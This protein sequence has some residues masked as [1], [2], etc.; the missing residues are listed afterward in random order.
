ME[1]LYNA[2]VHCEDEERI[3]FYNLDKFFVPHVQ[4]EELEKQAILR[5]PAWQ[6]RYHWVLSPVSDHSEDISSINVYNS[7]L[8]LRS[9]HCRKH[10]NNASISSRFC[11]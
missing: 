4:A 2:S 5:Q 1:S 6:E 9:P 3:N 11:R 8:K 7:T 10:P